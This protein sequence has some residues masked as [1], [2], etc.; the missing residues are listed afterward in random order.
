M[1]VEVLILLGHGPVV[2]N[3]EG[4]LLSYEPQFEKKALHIMRKKLITL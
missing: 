1:L 2:V 4:Q 3:C